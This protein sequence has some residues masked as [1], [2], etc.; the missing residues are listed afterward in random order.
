MRRTVP[1]L[2][3]IIGLALATGC[4][5]AAQRVDAE[6]FPAGAAASPSAVTPSTTAP[7]PS[8]TPSSPVPG[9]DAGSTPKTERPKIVL[10]PFGLGALKL[11]MTAEQARASGMVVTDKETVKPGVVCGE[12][13]RVRGVAYPDGGVMYATHLGVAGIPAYGSVATPEKIKI[14]STVAAVRK[15]YPDWRDGGFADAPGNSTAAYRIE[16]RDQ[17]VTD[18]ELLLKSQGKN[19]GRDYK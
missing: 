18:I 8:S 2:G 4:T 9:S 15:A 11:G 6:A 13:F 19:C 16:I 1:V 12:T 3:A 10:G 5:S 7:T 14:G 17:K